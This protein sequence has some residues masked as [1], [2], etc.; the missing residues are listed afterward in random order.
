MPGPFREIAT[1]TCI[2]FYLAISIPAECRRISLN[3]EYLLGLV[4]S[5]G[6][7]PGG[8]AAPQIQVVANK[9]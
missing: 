6:T 8:T 7:R 5:T 3:K 9:G 4:N 2:F 1:G